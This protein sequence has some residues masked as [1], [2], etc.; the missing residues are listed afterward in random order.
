ML[1]ELLGDIIGLLTGGIVQMAQSVG[2]GLNALVN[3][4]FLTTGEGG[5]QSLSIFG[6]VAVIFGGIALTIG[7][8]KLITRWITTL[9]GSKP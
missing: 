6:G 5:A 8:S 9:G 7:L 2:Q 4:L 1:T 3:N